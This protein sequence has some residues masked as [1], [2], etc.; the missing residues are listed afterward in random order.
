MTL[1]ILGGGQLARMLALAGHPLGVSFR[2]LEPAS[3]CPAAPIAYHLRGEYE[4]FQ[5][6]YSF[7][8]GLDAVTYEFENV[9]VASARWLNERV[10]V[11][12]T[13]DALEVGQDRIAEKSFFQKLGVP[14]PAFAAV[15]S[16]ADLDIAIARIGL[17]A[18]LKT[19]RFGYDGKGQAVLRTKDDVE[20]TWTTLG[21][22]PLILEGFVPFD[23]ELSIL[24]V[25]GR[26]GELAFYPLVENVHRAGILRVS[27]SPA[28]S[29]T[30]ELQVKAERI[31]AKAL[32]AL[33]YVGVLAVELFQVGDELLV[34]EMAPRVHNSGHWTIEGAETS[35][36]ENH[37]RAVA[38]LPLGSTAA[39]G[40][41]V[42][43]N[44]IG[45]W[46][47]PAAVLAIPGA[48]LHLYGKQPRPNRK[49]GHITVR[50]DS[51]QELLKR[52]HRVRGLMR[53]E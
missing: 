18:V 40:Q 43:I 6:L 47:N 1:G 34:N 23:R 22:R 11:Y 17:P 28:S 30:R 9:P 8:Q 48:H 27:T 15:D 53:E 2:I 12:P 39:V 21:G 49:V 29:A 37:V 5:S 14:V 25:R 16:R 32:E 41:S 45:G 35:Q 10:A 3:E 19:T 13:P 52:V 24:A 50:A 26:T 36:F 51:D 7:C 42:M 4:D 31:A 20:S 38:G 33:G 46:P 44:L